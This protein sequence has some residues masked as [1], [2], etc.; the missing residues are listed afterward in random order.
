MVYIG[1]HTKRR[2]YY[3]KIGNLRK[4]IAFAS[5]WYYAATV[6]VTGLMGAGFMGA[7]LNPIWQGALVFAGAT[8]MSFAVMFLFD[9][10]I[11][12]K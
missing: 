9:R 3:E 5:L 1:A 11:D 7:G 6:S 12:K 4:G 10:E 8:G 2:N